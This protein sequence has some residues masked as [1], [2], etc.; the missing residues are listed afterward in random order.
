MG[1]KHPSVTLPG[2]D[3]HGWSFRALS[4]PTFAR[5][6]RPGQQRQV[7]RRARRQERRQAH[8]RLKP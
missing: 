2:R 8:A 4:I 5:V 1:G 7:R 6:T 3:C